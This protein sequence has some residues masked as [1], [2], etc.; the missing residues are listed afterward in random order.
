MF[1]FLFS[2]SLWWAFDKLHI[3][4]VLPLFFSSS[5]WWAVDKLHILVVLSLFSFYFF[6][7][8]LLIFFQNIVRYMFFFLFFTLLYKVGFYFIF[9]F[10]IAYSHQFIFEERWYEVFWLWGCQFFVNAQLKMFI[11]LVA[12]L[13][14]CGKHSGFMLLKFFI[15]SSVSVGLSS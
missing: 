1:L 13:F 4:V 11:L 9:Y 12:V 8:T 7:I 10:L 5:L 2:F 15:V 6:L 14:L 3:L